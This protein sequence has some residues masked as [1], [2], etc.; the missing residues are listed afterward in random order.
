MLGALPSV[1]WDPAPWIYLN[2][3]G[4]TP[5]DVCQHLWNNF[6]YN[7]YIKKLLFGYFVDL[8]VPVAVLA[9]AELWGL[10]K[11]RMEWK[12][13]NASNYPSRKA[14][15]ASDF[16]RKKKIDENR[17]KP[18]NSMGINEIFLLGVGMNG[19][20]L[21]DCVASTWLLDGKVQTVGGSN[22]WEFALII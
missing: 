11:Y 16:P 20:W 3:T 13:G 5:L 4:E 8:A 9:C 2:Q 19:M 17:G 14:D 6:S 7:Y 18:A 10:W 12:A 15:A 22:K 21:W 1:M